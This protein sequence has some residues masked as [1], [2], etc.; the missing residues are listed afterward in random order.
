LIQRLKEENKATN[1]SVFAAVKDLPDEYSAL[2]IR[3][4]LK[5][6]V[7]FQTYFFRHEKHM[8]IFSEPASIQIRNSMK[9]QAINSL[10][11]GRIYVGIGIYRER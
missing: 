9:T 1:R 3:N 10:I 5:T 6:Q 4:Y 8:F 11:K 7:F 2:Q